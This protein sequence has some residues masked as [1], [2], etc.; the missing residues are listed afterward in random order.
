MFDVSG[1]IIGGVAGGTTAAIVATM[2]RPKP[3]A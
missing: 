2:L 1:A 3:K